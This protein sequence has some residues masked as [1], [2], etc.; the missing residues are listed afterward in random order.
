MNSFIYIAE[1]MVVTL[2]V[3]CFIVDMNGI[4][5][6]VGGSLFSAVFLHRASR[7]MSRGRRWLQFSNN[8]NN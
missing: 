4:V 2:H 7:S 1:K 6:G 3:Y 8:A 5:N